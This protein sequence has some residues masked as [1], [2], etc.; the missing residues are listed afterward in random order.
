MRQI[1]LLKSC[2]ALAAYFI[3][4]D[5][6]AQIPGLAPQKNWD[7]S[8]YI[9][10]V[11]SA[12]LPDDYAH[13]YDHLLHQRFNYEYRFNSQ[14]RFN[15]G[16]RNRLMAG[17]TAELPGY[18][19]FIDNDP[20][21]LDLSANWLDKN[22]V[23]GS[24][25]F[26][27]LYLDWS[28][29]E[30]QARLGRSRINWAM[31]TLWNP[32]DIFNSYSIYDF[33][34]EERAGSDSIL[35][36]RKLDFASSVEVVYNPSQDSDLNSYAG[37]Y[38][39]NQKGW[40]MQLLAGKSYLDHVLGG[41]F[42]GDIRGAGLRGEVTWFE[43]TQDSWFN[44]VE[45]IELKSALLASIE[46][47]YSFGGR[48]NWMGRA[49]ALYI[50]EPQEQNSAAEFLNLPLTART[51]SFSRMTYYSD[52]SFDISSLSRLTFSGSYYSDG[53]YY[54]GLTNSY[55]LADNWQLLMVLQRFDGVSGSLFGETPSILAFAQ[56]KWSF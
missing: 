47:D 24:S 18:A 50:S 40:D 41:G 29:Q 34:Y 8:G 25:Q 48:R 33:D 38:L 15:A 36:K 17:D 13:S 27:R 32:N 22:G 11:G 23:L 55:S 26:D 7:L 12:N 19:D 4:A 35:L 53:S 52:L 20:G 10:Y 56:L 14:L 44:D 31:T 21:Y 9:K 43:P 49:A 1:G 28:N 39:F 51:L 45:N 54:I 30:W 46:S 5:S 2:L 3:C 6:V 16:M 37:R 42:A